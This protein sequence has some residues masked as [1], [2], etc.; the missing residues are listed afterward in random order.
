MTGQMSVIDRVVFIKHSIL[1]DTVFCIH[2]VCRL[3]TYVICL[4]LLDVYAGVMREG[5]G[6]LRRVQ[7]C[8]LFTGLTASERIVS[9]VV[10]N[11]LFKN[12]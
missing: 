5:V 1:M 11:I 3:V 12:K 4:P 6:G 9:S 8:I 7:N 2:N 10:S